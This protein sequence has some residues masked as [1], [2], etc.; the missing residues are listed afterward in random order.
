MMILPAAVCF[1]TTMMIAQTRFLVGLRERMPVS[2]ACF[3]GMFR[4]GDNDD[5]DD[6]DG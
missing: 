1:S 5:D 3:E 6:D 2:K 4:S